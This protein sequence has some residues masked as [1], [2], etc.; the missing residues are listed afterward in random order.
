MNEKKRSQLLK[1]S[2]QTLDELIPLIMHNLRCQAH[3][4]VADGNRLTRGQGHILW[5]IKEGIR[6]V[7]GLAQ[8]SQVSKPTI[9]RMADLLVERG[10]LRRERDPDDRRTVLLTITPAGESQMAARR[11]SA[12]AWISSSLTTLSEQELT[13]LIR[14]LDILKHALTTESGCGCCK[15]NKH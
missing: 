10:F 3:Q 14:G 1:T 9:S 5:K 4:T 8:H 2:I 7:A 15:N 13:D 6:T 12:H 11:R